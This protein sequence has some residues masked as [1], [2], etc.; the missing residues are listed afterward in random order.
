MDIVI[1]VN[2]PHLISAITAK[3][4]HVTPIRALTPEFARLSEVLMNAHVLESSL[5]RIVKF[6]LARTKE[7][8]ERMDH[9]SARLD[10]LEANVS[11]HLALIINVIMELV[12]FQERITFATVIQT[13]LV[14]IASTKSLAYQTHAKMEELALK[15]GRTILAVVNHRFFLEKNVNQTTHASNINAQTTTN[16]SAFLTKMKNPNVSLKILD[17]RTRKQMYVKLIRRIKKY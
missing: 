17:L 5:V 9:V 15:T 3:K 1:H 4:P 16:Q 10:T 12:L 6:A 2:V 7:H 14:S 8:A 11:I 13:M